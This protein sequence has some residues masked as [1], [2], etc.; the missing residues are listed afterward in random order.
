MA[1]ALV[2]DPEHAALLSMDYQ[3]A[4]L[5][6]YPG[7]SEALIERAGAVQRAA[8]AA[9]MLVVH[10]VVGFRPGYPE[11]SAR[12]V[13]FSTIK[14]G[15]RFTSADAGANEPVI[16]PKDGDIVVTKH[17]VGA[18]MGTDLDMILRA[19]EVETLVMFGV[20]TSGV[21]LS[22]LRHAA[23]A[24]YRCIVVRDCC[25]DRDPDVNACLLDKVFPRQA[26]VVE[27]EDVIAAIG[28]G[29]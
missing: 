23:D 17:R 26:N 14:Q 2:I 25:A 12:N 19:Q 9:G 13:A 16:P 7:D 5:G 24:D 6:A 28:A 3:S 15:G 21:V 22:T 11:V 20:S 4:I 18:F 8:R 29:A 10:V 1:D 27:S